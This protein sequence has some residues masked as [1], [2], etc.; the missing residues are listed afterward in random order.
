MLS[1]YGIEDAGATV[2]AGGVVYGIGVALRG[3]VGI[4]QVMLVQDGS[5]R[6]VT[7]CVGSRSVFWVCV[8]EICIRL[9]CG[10]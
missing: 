7:H 10:G 5:G 1:G 4:R 8:R 6:G 2:S 9:A 3:R